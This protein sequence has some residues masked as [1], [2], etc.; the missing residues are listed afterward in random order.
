MVCT[1]RG[2]YVTLRK[3]AGKV[4]VKYSVKTS[5][6][7]NLEGQENFELSLLSNTVSKQGSS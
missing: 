3:A 5:T 4:K 7:Q 2:M 1:L 6:T